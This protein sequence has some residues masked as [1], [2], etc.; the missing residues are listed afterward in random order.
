MYKNIALVLIILGAISSGWGAFYLEGS[1]HKVTESEHELTKE[2]LRTRDLAYAE[3]EVKFKALQKE[4]RNIIDS[5]QIS[6]DYCKKQLDERIKTEEEKDRRSRELR[7]L[8]T[9]TEQELEEYANNA[10]M[11]YPAYVSAHQQA[12]E[13]TVR[14]DETGAYYDVK[15]FTER[16]IIPPAIARMLLD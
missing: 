3:L 5:M 8:L 2:V 12:Y 10:A 4:S 1:K 7:D 9:K 11:F 6:A 14:Y 13:E 16:C 15:T